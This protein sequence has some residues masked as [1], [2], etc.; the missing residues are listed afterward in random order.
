MEDIGVVLTPEGSVI[1]AHAQ[2]IDEPGKT[3]LV[4][5]S[6]RLT[7][8]AEFRAWIEDVMSRHTLKPGEQWMVCRDYA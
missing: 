3:R 5:T 1:Q 2:Q 7:T 6:G 4:E 8:E